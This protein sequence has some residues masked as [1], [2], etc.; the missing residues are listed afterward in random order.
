MLI[1]HTGQQ[2]DTAVYRL[3]SLRPL[4]FVGLISYSLYLWHWPVIAFAENY[5][6]RPIT[7]G[8]AL[9]LIVVSIAI[10]TASWRYVERPFR[11]RRAKGDPSPRES[12]FLGGLGALGLTACVGGAIY[13]GVDCKG[14]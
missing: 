12:A 3:L 1:I 5:V 10:A 2:R 7:L 8:E 4:V 14:A 11:L 13:L 9:I 6:G